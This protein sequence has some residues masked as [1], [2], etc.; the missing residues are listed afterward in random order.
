MVLR[1]AVINVYPVPPKSSRL[2]IR[3]LKDRGVEV[4]YLPLQFIGLSVGEGS[5]SLQIGDKEIELDG[6]I[7]RGLG[8]I[9][10]I[11]QF[12]MRIA[13]LRFL[14]LKGTYLMNPLDFLIISRNKLETLVRL[15]HKG[16]PVPFTFSSENIKY[17][18]TVLREKG[19]KE[20]VLKPITGSRGYG[21]TLLKDPD[22]FYQ[23][24]SLLLQNNIPPLVQ[25]FVHIPQRDIRAFV[26][27]DRVVASMYRYSNGCW[28]TNIAQGAIGVKT[29]LEPEVEELAI[30]SMQ[31]MNLEYAG[32]D[33][34]EENGRFYVLEVNSSPD[35]EGLMKATGIDIPRLLAEHFL[36]K[37]KK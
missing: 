5:F 9:S 25:R 14:E 12:Y 21:T 32:V 6:G 37:L 29:N 18:Y 11:G 33:I 13:F 28:K 10:T 8:M 23:I 16:I 36:M 22:V 15:Y 34:A 31:A 2:I 4:K 19:L 20:F 1:V 24:A 35:F 30:R 17:L 7:V 26:I 27:G 3:A